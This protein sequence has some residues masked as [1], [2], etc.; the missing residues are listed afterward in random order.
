MA[1]LSRQ[2]GGR[3]FCTM[4]KG[5][6]PPEHGVRPPPTAQA[7]L[8]AKDHISDLPAS[9]LGCTSG[10]L[11]AKAPSGFG[12]TQTSTS[13]CAGNVK[14]L[15]TCDA[16]ETLPIF[17]SGAAVGLSRLPPALVKSAACTACPYAFL[18]PC[19]T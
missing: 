11:S 13:H 18:S 1:F 15:L 7:P 10:F 19:I 14:T 6:R 3:A 2:E 17:T 16:S 4:Q 8:S 5:D 9:A 12:V